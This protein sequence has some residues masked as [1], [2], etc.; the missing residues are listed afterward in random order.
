[1]K[2]IIKTILLGIMTLILSVCRYPITSQAAWQ[3][4][5]PWY[6]AWEANIIPNGTTPEQLILE[7]INTE[8]AI[9][10]LPA[11]MLNQ[12]LID[13]AQI[14]ITETPIKWSHWRPN[15][16]FFETVND[17]TKAENLYCSWN[18]FYAN[19]DPWYITDGWMHSRSHRSI[20]LD[21]RYTQVG[22]AFWQDPENGYIYSVAE[23]S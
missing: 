20:M 5:L 13:A 17:M 3:D 11:L 19:L 18:P 15:G 1:M 16:T 2:K 6:D 8:R 21:N 10:G 12:D 22:I 23:F 4:E 14:R 7:D 9:Y